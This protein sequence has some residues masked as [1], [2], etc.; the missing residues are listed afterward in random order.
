MIVAA[1][2]LVAV[3]AVAV[4]VSV[5]FRVAFAAAANVAVAVPAAAVAV[6]EFAVAVVVVGVE[7]YHC[8]ISCY[9]DPA[10][11]LSHPRI[12]CEAQCASVNSDCQANRTECYR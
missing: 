2:S 1:V 10:W 5:V 6:V 3:V 8:C 9:R 7:H 12:R 4:V 11:P